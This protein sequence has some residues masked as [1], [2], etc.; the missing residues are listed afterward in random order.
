MKNKS[1]GNRHADQGADRRVNDMFLQMVDY[2]F[3]GG[4]AG[5]IE[6]PNKED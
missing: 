1:K 4:K 5:K 6:I 3:F 2:A